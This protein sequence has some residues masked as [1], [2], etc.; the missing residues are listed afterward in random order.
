MRQQTGP[1][2]PAAEGGAG[3]E[4][5]GLSSTQLLR[6]NFRLIYIRILRNRFFPDRKVE[7]PCVPE[8]RTGLIVQNVHQRNVLCRVSF[9]AWPLVSVVLFGLAAGAWA[10]QAASAQVSS[11]PS[12]PDAALQGT[13]HGVVTSEDGTVYEGVHVTLAFRGAGAQAARTQTTDSGGAFT[14]T[15]VPPGAFK[16][17]LASGGFKTQTVAGFLHP[18]QDYDA[19]NIV[20]PVASAA[21][22]VRVSASPVE[23]A[24]E[25]LNVEEQQRVL[26]VIPNYYVSYD[27]NAAPL[28]KRQKYQ[29]AWK[30]NIDPVTWL[31][32]GAIAGFEQATN[33][34]SGYGQG[35][36][37]YGKRFGAAYA[38]G[39]IS[40]ML[41]NAVLPSLFKQDPRYFYKGTGSVRSRVWYAIYNSVLCKGDNG[42]WQFDYSALMGSLAAGGIS[43]LYYPAANRNGVGLTFES[44]ALGVAGSAAQ[45]L[46]Q[47]FVIKKL[48]PKARKHAQDAP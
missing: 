42:R 18:G 6:C 12:A 44:T 45:N 41:G 23:L 22:E 9:F 2:L 19:K 1:P 33:A 24:Q 15:H 10:Q 25:Q 30:T 8:P 38:D 26:G 17:T 35:A 36:Q 28:D 20:L 48:T 21:T 29:L 43:N 47:E 27:G 7:E 34:F 16:L 37:G 14:F 4:R 40:T 32:T 31:A 3:Q 46:I 11:L 13:I 39:F 5:A